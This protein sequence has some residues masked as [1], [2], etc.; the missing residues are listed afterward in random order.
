MDYEARLVDLLKANDRVMRLLCTVRDLGLDHWCLAAG[1]I[2]NVVWD[3]LHGYTEPTLPSD[4]DVLVYDS[5]RTDPRYERELEGLL[6]A[7]VPNARWEVV[8]LSGP[9]GVQ[10]LEGQV[11]SAYDRG[12]TQQA[13]RR[14]GGSGRFPGQPRSLFATGD[15]FLTNTPTPTVHRLTPLTNTCLQRPPLVAQCVG[16][17]SPVTRPGR[18]PQSRR[19][20]RSAAHPRHRRRHTC[21]DLPSP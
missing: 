3:K 13:G 12:T 16:L 1:T 9:D 2:R 8:N 17:P 18:K 19:R 7:A 5:V 20:R 10:R 21:T 15:T 4:V 14:S 11:A 6:S